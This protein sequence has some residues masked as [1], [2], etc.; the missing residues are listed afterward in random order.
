M[1]ARVRIEELHISG[2]KN[3]DSSIRLSGC[4]L[5]ADENGS[6]KTGVLQAIQFAIEGRTALGDRPEATAQLIR[7]GEAS[8]R[9]RLDDGFSFERGL[10]RDSRSGTITQ[11]LEVTGNDSVKLKDTEPL[12]KTRVGELAEMY[13]LSLFTGLSQDKQR[14][15]ILDLC[16]RA[17]KSAELDVDGIVR[18][19]SIE[20]LKLERGAGT[21]DMAIKMHRGTQAELIDFL[22]ADLAKDR[23]EAFD[24]IMA[25]VREEIVGELTES[26]GAALAKAKSV[27][28]A[29]KSACDQANAAKARLA[30]QK[31]AMRVVA[32]TVETMKAD[33]EGLL[34]QR[35]QIVGQIENQK[36]R[37]ESLRSLQNRLDNATTEIHR[38]EQT[39]AGVKIQTAADA[40]VLR[41]AAKSIR[42]DNAR[43]AETVARFTDCAGA[44]LFA[45]AA[46]K[47]RKLANP[48][49]EEFADA[50]RAIAGIEADLKA[51]IH[52][53]VQAATRA[54]HAADEVRREAVRQR[55]TI[56]AEL[57]KAEAAR[58]SAELAI[59]EYRSGPWSRALAKLKSFLAEGPT[60]T[61]P[62][63]QIINELQTIIET[64]AVVGREAE[65]T[66]RLNSAT[67]VVDA[68]RA[69]LTEADAGVSAT[70]KTAHDAANA[71]QA[72]EGKA[73]AARSLTADLNAKL[74]SARQKWDTLRAA[75]TAMQDVERLEQQAIETLATDLERR[76]DGIAAA[77][78]LHD[79][80]LADLEAKRKNRIE[81]ERQMNELR[82]AGGWVPAEQLEA[83][84]T[85]LTEQIANVDADLDL[86]NRFQALEAELQKAIV[87]T[88]SE[89]VRHDVAKQ[90]AAAIRALR[91]GLMG[92]LV[93]PLLE[94]MNK[95]LS[96]AAPGRVAYCELEQVKGETRKPIF[97]IGWEVDGMYRVP[98]PAL[99]GGEAAL[100]G[101][102]LAYALVCIANPPLRLLLIEA[103]EVDSNHMTHL[104][105]G[106]RAVAGDV[107]NILVATCNEGFST[108]IEGW[109]QITLSETVAA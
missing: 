12:V 89:T 14:S 92:E 6:G 76:A 79:Q 30:D 37:E 47:R 25:A 93:R 23:R 70:E 94:R 61:A 18:R 102:A 101:G 90:I 7:N 75:K 67:T 28:N 73:A 68:M 78:K 34:K 3:L 27:E 50:E 100:F 97:E 20:W 87:A 62:Q 1:G 57:Q 58:Q 53:D 33:R 43:V 42:T 106:L 72:V 82:S 19:I 44:P 11:T 22:K 48:T 13:N 17:Q 83:Q 24:S 71:A 52:P 84:R 55:D 64:G 56:G 108:D 39:L 32:A 65:L 80:N 103:A 95:F 4:N 69:R 60:L 59:E 51:V 9:V 98:L 99:S 40:E 77:I 21:V 5:M 105:N 15:K 86:K 81:T 85:A 104:L 54:Y 10:R 46:E 49:S 109:N 74:T 88:E 16:G 96:V 31:N 29:S 38:L 107:G 41:V 36:G 63:F 35:E 8:V 2:F 26:I 66:S 91:D 45:Q